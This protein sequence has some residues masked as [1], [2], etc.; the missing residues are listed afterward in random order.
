[1]INR[2]KKNGLTWSLISVALVLL[3]GNV[4]TN[5]LDEKEAMAKYSIFKAPEKIIFYNNRKQ[6]IIVK[7]SKEFDKI[8]NM[9]NEGFGNSKDIGLTLSLMEITDEEYIK[10]NSIAIEF[11]Y[12]KKTKSRIKLNEKMRRITYWRIFIPLNEKLE[13]NE[14]FIGTKEKYSNAG[15]KFVPNMLNFQYLIEKD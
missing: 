8:I 2:F 1:M 14:I 15:I 5:N 9:L 11:I 4:L 7:P 12:K 6:N 10:D 13:A 3:V